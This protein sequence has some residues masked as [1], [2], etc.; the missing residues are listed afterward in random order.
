MAGIYSGFDFFRRSFFVALEYETPYFFA[1][2][3]DVFL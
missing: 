1:F 2:I 3:I